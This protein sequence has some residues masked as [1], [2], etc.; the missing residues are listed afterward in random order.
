MSAVPAC[1]AGAGGEDHDGPPTASTTALTALR[2][3]EA[4]VVEAGRES[5]LKAYAEIDLR[6][7]E[8][9]RETLERG[10]AGPECLRWLRQLALSWNSRLRG[11]NALKF[12][13][14]FTLLDAIR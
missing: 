7:V 13:R 3:L 12:R 14:V 11:V 1:P 10:A 2:L 6:V 9:L 4:C 5:A 8:S